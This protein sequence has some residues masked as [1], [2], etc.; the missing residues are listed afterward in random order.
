[1]Q[2]LRF[3]QHRAEGWWCVK[4]KT[5]KA[6]LPFRLSPLQYSVNKNSRVATIFCSAN[7]SENL[8]MIILLFDYC[9]VFSA[10]APCRPPEAVPNANILGPRE[11]TYG[12]TV[13]Y[14]CHEGYVII[15]VSRRTCRADKRYSGK[16]P[17]CKGILD[18]G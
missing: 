18:K 10:V 9:N 4:S 15:G 11:P 8:C 17:E 13:T 2:S 7:F 5:S 12:Q 3:F 14:D 6:V 1:M 16:P